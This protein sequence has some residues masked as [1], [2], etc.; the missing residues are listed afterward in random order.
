MPGLTSTSRTPVTFLEGKRIIL[1]E[2]VRDVLA[3]EWVQRASLGR[4]GE[5]GSEAPS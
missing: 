5:R 3:D 4:R 1:G 2:P